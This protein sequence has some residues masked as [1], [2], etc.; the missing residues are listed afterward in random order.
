MTGSTTANRME[1]AYICDKLH[2]PETFDPQHHQP[3]ATPLTNAF[4]KTKN[5]LGFMAFIVFSLVLVLIPTALWILSIYLAYNC[6]RG[7]ITQQVFGVITAFL[8]PLLFLLFYLVVHIMLGYS[9]ASASS[10]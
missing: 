9:C 5:A 6:Y 2:I 10:K 1:Y 4:R 3:P 7:H 8:F